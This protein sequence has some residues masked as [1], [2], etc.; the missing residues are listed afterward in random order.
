M[1]K[2]KVDGSLIIIVMGKRNMT[3]ITRMGKKMD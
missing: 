1:G 3:I 2:K